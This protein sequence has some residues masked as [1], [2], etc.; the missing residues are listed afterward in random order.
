MSGSK[1]KE[2]TGSG[3]FAEKG[4]NGDSEASNPANRTS[5]RMYQVLS[6]LRNVSC[7]HHLVDVYVYLLLVFL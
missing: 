7:Y 5:V 3:I 2:M 6:F 4:E 1:M